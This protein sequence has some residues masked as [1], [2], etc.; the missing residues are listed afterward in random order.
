M[1]QLTI[2]EIIKVANIIADLPEATYG[3][4]EPLKEWIGYDFIFPAREDSLLYRWEM[5]RA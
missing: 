1:R 4:T 2:K 3:D 5:N